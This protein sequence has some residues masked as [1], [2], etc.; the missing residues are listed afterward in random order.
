MSVSHLAQGE[1]V[2]PILTPS[3]HREGAENVLSHPQAPS[4]GTAVLSCMAGSSCPPFH[5]AFR[6]K[7]AVSRQSFSSNASAAASPEEAIGS[8]PSV[9]GIKRSQMLS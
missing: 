4:P 7:I 8:T 1:S 3:E 6:G 9:Q 2:A 5:G